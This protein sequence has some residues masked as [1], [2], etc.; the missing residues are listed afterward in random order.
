MLSKNPTDNDYATV[1]GIV[2]FYKEQWFHIFLAN[3]TRRHFY[4]LCGHNI[5]ASNIGIADS[6]TFW[7]TIPEEEQD[8]EVCPYEFEVDVSQKIFLK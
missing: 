5:T 8:P 1:G 3:E 2:T 7:F 4:G 6:P